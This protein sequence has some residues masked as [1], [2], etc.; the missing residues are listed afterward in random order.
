MIRGLLGR[1]T[2][3]RRV[4]LKRIVDREVDKVLL[5]VF[6]HCDASWPAS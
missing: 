4:D 2:E 1:Q 3:D 6:G 5:V